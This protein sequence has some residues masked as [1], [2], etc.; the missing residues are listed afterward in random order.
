MINIAEILK[1]CPKG[2][3]LYSPLCGECKYIRV[4]NNLIKVE[5]CDEYIHAF[6]S[7]G[8]R[9]RNGECLLF[10]SKDQKDWSTFQRPFKDGDIV[11]YNDS[12]SIFKEWGD[13]TLFRTY[14]T[15][16]IQFLDIIDI[17][18]PLFGKSVRREIRLA[19]EEEKEKLF[20]AIKDNGYRWNAEAKTLERLIR[21]K[22]K[23]G[24]VIQDIDTYK[25]KITAV[26]IEDEC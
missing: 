17:N 19:T 6:F 23:V 4:E 18:T 14:V 8:L 7:D 25:V 5:D 16:Y 15:T 21:L 10:P 20:Q 11:F 13:E 3:K 22:F 26:N 9:Y 24:D 2:T 12:I 1:D